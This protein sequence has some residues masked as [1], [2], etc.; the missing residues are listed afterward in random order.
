[1][2]LTRKEKI[3]LLT[4]ISFMHN[5]GEYFVPLLK[6]GTPEENQRA[7]EKAKVIYKD[8][9]RRIRATLDKPENRA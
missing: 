4:A 2:A 8:L 6:K 3:A 5:H 1:M 9:H 7:W